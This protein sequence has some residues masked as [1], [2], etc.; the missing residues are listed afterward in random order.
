MHSMRPR[1]SRRGSQKAPMLELI[2]A[3]ELVAWLACK[4]SAPQTDLLEQGSLSHG[5]PQYSGMKFISAV[6]KVS[7]S[8]QSCLIA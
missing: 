4:D 1:N 2:L 8:A 6:G 3:F 5:Y 7:L